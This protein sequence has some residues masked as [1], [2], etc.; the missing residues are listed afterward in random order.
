[1]CYPILIL[2]H[3]GYDLL[4]LSYNRILKLRSVIAYAILTAELSSIV[5]LDE[6]TL[7]LKV[8]ENVNGAVELGGD[9][10]AVVIAGIL[11]ARIVLRSTIVVLAE[12]SHIDLTSTF[13]VDRQLLNAVKAVGNP[14]KGARSDG[15][16]YSEDLVGDRVVTLSC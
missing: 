5:L 9:R 14:V 10:V 7:L 12:H 11:T 8:N 4:I 16:R 15:L 13:N 2:L 1:V 3:C 6:A